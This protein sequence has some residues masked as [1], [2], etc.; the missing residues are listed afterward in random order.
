MFDRPHY[1]MT[2]G[3]TQLG[4]AEIWQT[5]IHYAPMDANVPV[6]ALV[7]ALPNISLSDIWEDLTPIIGSSAVNQRYPNSVHLR[8]LKLAVMGTDGH[9]ATGPR[10]HEGDVPGSVAQAN[11]NPPQLAVVF[12]MWSGQ[13]FGQAQRGR[14][15]F[16]CPSDF[17]TAI[18]VATGQVGSSNAAAFGLQVVTSLANANGEVSTVPVPTMPAIMSKLGAGTTRF[19]S[20][21]AVGRIIDTQRSRRN[22]LVEAPVYSPWPEG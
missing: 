22:Q 10:T 18:N 2:F 16:P 4:T 19:V 3:G 15:Y 14:M 17:L 13:R 9:Y 1:Y 6:Q 11:G 7:D 20:Q 12:S 5:G 21:Y 8:W